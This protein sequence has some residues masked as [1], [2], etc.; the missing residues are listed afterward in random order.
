M[1]V[2]ISYK[3]RKTPDTEKEVQHLI[4]KL[5]KR[6]QAFRP[7]LVHL[8]GV[9]EENS[10]REGFVVSL[11]LRLPSGQMAAQ[12]TAPT[13]AAAVKSC[14]DDLLQQV[15]KHKDMLRSSHNW[16]RRRSG[17]GRDYPQVPFE[18]TF[19]A[20]QPTTASRND[21][22]SYVNANV[23]RLQRFV[24]RELYFREA[25]G[26][27][28]AGALVKEEVVDEAVA[29]AL[30]DG[31]EKPERLGLEAWL[32][33]LALRSMDQLA[34]SGES[35][36]SDVHLEDS[37]RRPNERASDEPQLQ[38]HQ[39]DESFTEETVIADR[40]ASTPEDIAYSDEMLKLVQLALGG[41]SHPDREAFILHTLEGFSVPEVAAITDRQPEQVW[42]SIAAARLHLRHFPPLAGHFVTNPQGKLPQDVGAH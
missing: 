7:E 11:N 38:F 3:I 40:R 30:G 13:A 18:Q 34:A 29:R 19:A 2:H 21:I 33:R 41:T 5:Q 10:P 6:L 4:E 12:R 31:S 37:V 22:R 24:E 8:K 39:P 16:S 25:A 15:T 23:P 42:A 1:N 32:Y 35:E 14:F 17:G 26:Q 27:I 20:V 36:I 9:F 28:E